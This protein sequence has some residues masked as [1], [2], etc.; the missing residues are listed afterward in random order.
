MVRTTEIF[1]RSL[2]S[3]ASVEDKKLAMMERLGKRKPR[4][5]ILRHRNNAVKTP[6]RA[7]RELRNSSMMEIRGEEVE[8]YC[9]LVRAGRI[10]H[11]LRRDVCFMHADKYL[12]VLVF[13][14]FKRAKLRLDEFTE[15]NFWVALYISQ[16]IEEDAT[17]F[18]WEILPWA[19]GER[20][21]DK[22][23]VFFEYKLEFFRR[24]NYRAA[25]SKD[26]IERV[27]SL[28]SCPEITSRTRAANHSGS[29]KVEEDLVDTYEPA[30]PT[31]PPHP[32]ARC[33]QQLVDSPTAQ[34]EE[35]ETEYVVL[36]T[37]SAQDGNSSIFAED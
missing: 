37:L 23:P 27:L 19:L 31:Q 29:W 18:R 25:A 5:L 3:D 33:S 32:C 1:L 17:F 13:I 15:D 22:Q 26:Q 30:G 2:L 35:M 12:L 16:D 36:D 24:M 8:A 9:N 7:F 11:F 34:M 14:Y 6:V 20:W 28:L 21:E 4:K 10:P